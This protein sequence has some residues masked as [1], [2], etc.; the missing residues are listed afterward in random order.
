MEKGTRR[1]FGSTI[2]NAFSLRDFNRISLDGLPQ[3][4]DLSEEKVVPDVEEALDRLFEAPAGAI[5]KNIVQNER[6]DLQPE[7]RFELVKFVAL[8]WYRTPGRFFKQQEDMRRLI[9]TLPQPTNKMRP[10][11]KAGDGEDPLRDMRLFAMPFE[12]VNLASVLQ[13]ADLYL[14]KLHESEF[15]LG[16]DPVSVMNPTIRLAS[17]G[18]APFTITAGGSEV[19]LPISP[20]LGIHL[21]TRMDVK[22]GDIGRTISEPIILD[23]SHRTLLNQLQFENALLCVTS[24]SGGFP[25]I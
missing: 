5:I 11:G 9:P 17:N 19:F 25:D 15:L 21:H 12:V 8:Q 16:D 22:R 13:R 3:F 18:V 2:A 6:L 4:H 10:L 23:A 20:Q 14:H 1:I 7:Q 24:Q